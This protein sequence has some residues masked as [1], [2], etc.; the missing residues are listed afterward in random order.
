M[1]G[2]GSR[3]SSGTTD[4]MFLRS[5]P[6]IASYVSQFTRN[7]AASAWEYYMQITIAAVARLRIG[8]GFHEAQPSE[9]A[10]KMLDS[11]I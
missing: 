6:K 1:E 9:I 3:V 2:P 8:I 11:T 4:F 7:D 5:Y 10:G